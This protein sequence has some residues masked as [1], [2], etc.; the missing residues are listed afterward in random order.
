MAVTIVMLLPLL[1]YAQMEIQWAP[2][3]AIW[4]YQILF[5][6]GTS[7]QCKIECIKDTL[8]EERIC[9]ILQSD[10]LLP[11]GIR[12][13]IIYQEQDKI[14][15]YADGVF[16]LLYD[17]S[18]KRGD[19]LEIW[20]P[21]SGDENVSENTHREIV[22]SVG[23]VKLGNKEYRAYWASRLFVNGSSSPWLLGTSL[24][25]VE[26]IGGLYFFFPQNELIE[27]ATGPLLNYQ[28]SCISLRLN[29]SSCTSFGCAYIVEE[30]CIMVG[31][32]ALN[33]ESLLRIYPIP[34]SSL[35]KVS[36]DEIKYTDYHL[37]LYDLNG[38]LIFTSKM[39]CSDDFDIDI[40]S[41]ENGIYVLQIVNAKRII[42]KKIIIQH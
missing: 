9:K 8:I 7:D 40:S 6:D 14:Y 34:A 23:I 24:P 30:T 42:S 37:T 39:L 29:R 28:D 21:Y 16:G 27:T 22:D 15:Q 20:V 18:V 25:I 41:F 2:V 3:G 17:F 35:L 5:I 31:I 10:C 13:A 36:L 12:R 11:G 26:K 1:T 19:T 33:V 32:D 38:R 4:D